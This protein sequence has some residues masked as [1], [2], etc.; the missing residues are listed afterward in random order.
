MT[1]MY[2]SPLE[3]VAIKIQAGDTETNITQLCSLLRTKL[4]TGA[5]SFVASVV[6][7]KITVWNARTGHL[8]STKTETPIYNHM[9][10][11]NEH[12]IALS[13][14]AK[15]VQVDIYDTRSNNIRTLC[16]LNR[17]QF[18]VYR[19]YY[20]RKN[21]LITLLGTTLNLWNNTGKLLGTVNGHHLPIKHVQRIN[22][23]TVACAPYKLVYIKVF[24]LDSFDCVHV[25]RNNQDIHGLS[26]WNGNLYYYTLDKLF[27]WDTRCAS[28]VCSVP[29]TLK[30]QILDESAYVCTIKVENIIHLR[31]VN[32]KRGTTITITSRDARSSFIEF[33][34]K[35]NTIMYDDGTPTMY[36]VTSGKYYKFEEY[37]RIPSKIAI[38]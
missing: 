16:Q 10:F 23:Y 35:G 32:W 7:R 11:I 3:L 21:V 5:D 24:D 15:Q 12:E 4:N 1:H 14:L 37:N 36:H 20:L 19:L 13:G 9:V 25:I 8:V 6:P 27:K 28:I 34:V 33:T 22:D 31:V 38:W 18:E 17:K 30:I 26:S 2:L 29:D